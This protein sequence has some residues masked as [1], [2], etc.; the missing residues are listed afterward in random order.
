MFVDDA[1]GEGE[2]VEMGTETA[3]ITANKG[4]AQ[5]QRRAALRQHGLIGLKQ[6]LVLAD[7]VAFS[8]WVHVHL[9]VTAKLP[10]RLL[11][12][13]AYLC[14]VAL[15]LRLRFETTQLAFNGDDIRNGV[16]RAARAE[17]PNVD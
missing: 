2:D 6:W 1:G 9:D 11:E 14:Q 12:C 16:A 13:L 17:T 10:C 7:A 3:G 15:P 5:L 4:G 8:M